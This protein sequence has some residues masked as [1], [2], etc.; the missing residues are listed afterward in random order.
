MSSPATCMGF[1]A[2]FGSLIISVEP[3]EG[4]WRI[5]VMYTERDVVLHRARTATL[6]N[7]KRCAQ[8]LALIYQATQNGSAK[9]TDE[10]LVWTAAK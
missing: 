4:Q 6:E 9:V 5:T 1:A 8:D 7:A 3:V 2:R 10:E